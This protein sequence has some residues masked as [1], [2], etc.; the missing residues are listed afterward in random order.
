MAAKERER[1]KPL[2]VCTQLPSLLYIESG[3]AFVDKSDCA[4]K[5]GCHWSNA[6]MPMYLHVQIHSSFAEKDLLGKLACG[7]NCLEKL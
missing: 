7:V 6:S 2:V 1:K 5:Q 3:A 4:R